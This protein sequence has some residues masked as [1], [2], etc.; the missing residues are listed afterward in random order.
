MDF[1][2]IGMNYSDIESTFQCATIDA[3]DYN[4]ELQKLNSNI[5]NATIHLI[6]KTTVQ[7]HVLD[8]ILDFENSNQRS[9]MQDYA[10]YS[11]Q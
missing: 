10:W 3:L 11:K 2:N 5:F 9:F 1:L 4:A 8:T 6:I 7:F